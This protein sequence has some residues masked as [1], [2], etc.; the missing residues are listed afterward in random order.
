MDSIDIYHLSTQGHIDENIIE[1]FGI[2]KV[3]NLKN[4][5]E[6]HTIYLV[7]LCEKID[8]KN[9]ITYYPICFK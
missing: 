6:T 7:E 1:E 8:K 4:F 2:D 9:K 5:L 3:S